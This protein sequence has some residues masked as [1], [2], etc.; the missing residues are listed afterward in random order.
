MIHEIGI[1]QKLE[2]NSSTMTVYNNNK[3]SQKYA[4]LCCCSFF[5]LII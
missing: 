3:Y 1:K 4:T 2:I 5:G